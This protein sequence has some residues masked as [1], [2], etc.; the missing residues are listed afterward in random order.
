[1]DPHLPFQHVYGNPAAA[2]GAAAAARAAAAVAGPRVAAAGGAV[3]AG[4][5]NVVVVR[6][7][8]QKPRTLEL[9]WK[10]DVVFIDH[11][12][13]LHKQYRAWNQPNKS[14]D[15][16]E[17]AYNLVAEH[18]A[19]KG[20][21]LHMLFAEAPPAPAAAGGGG[22]LGAGSSRPAAPATPAAAAPAALPGRLTP[23]AVAAAAVVA[24]PRSAGNGSGSSSRSRVQVQLLEDEEVNQIIW[25]NVPMKLWDYL[26]V[27]LYLGAPWN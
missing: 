20:Y 16:P 22:A 26:K 18:M 23:A 10:Y 12:K 6:R 11:I 8:Q 13:L 24:D 5:E 19:V 9:H 15:I 25:D 3:A 1:M 14:W 4:G 2:A 7:S 17:H 21:R 27:G